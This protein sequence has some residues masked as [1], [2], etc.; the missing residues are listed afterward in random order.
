MIGDDTIPD[1]PFCSL[2]QYTCGDLYPNL[3][4]LAWSM[5][6]F[7]SSSAGILALGINPWCVCCC[8]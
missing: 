8:C 4:N 5:S 2:Q 1:G 7:N 6:T 3:F